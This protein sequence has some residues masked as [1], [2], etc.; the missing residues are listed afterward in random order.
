MFG[1]LL[2][3][4]VGFTFSGK[5]ASSNENFP[6]IVSSTCI[7]IDITKSFVTEDTTAGDIEYVWEMGDGN[8]VKGNKFK[9]CYKEKGLYQ[10]R[11]NMHYIKTDIYSN[12]ELVSEIKVGEE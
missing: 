8:T 11:M 3:L 6:V 9:Y 7:E 12:D 4:V 5:T 2:G 1:L 10:I